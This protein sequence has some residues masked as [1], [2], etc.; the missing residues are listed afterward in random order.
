[1]GNEPTF[2]TSFEYKNY[3]HFVEFEENDTRYQLCRHNDSYVLMHN[4][5][6]MMFETVSELKR[7]WTKHISKLPVIYK[8]QIQRI[9]DPVLFYQIFFVGQDK[10]GTSNIA[11]AGLLLC[12]TLNLD[13]RIQVLEF[14][15]GIIG[16]KLP[17]NALLRFVPCRSP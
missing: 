4:D 5:A 15:S 8:N 11:N 17:V 9:V 3:Y 6:I 2:P 14:R 10:K 7:Y 13:N 12:K 16:S 1:M